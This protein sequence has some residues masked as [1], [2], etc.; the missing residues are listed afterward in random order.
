M[1]VYPINCK[2]EQHLPEAGKSGVG[3]PSAAHLPAETDAVPRRQS[4]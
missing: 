4:G 1:C 2:G 3:N